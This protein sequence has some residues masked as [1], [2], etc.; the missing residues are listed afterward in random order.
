MVPQVMIVPVVVSGVN[1]TTA[2]SGSVPNTYPI[3]SFGGYAMGPPSANPPA[4]DSAGPAIA[5]GTNPVTDLPGTTYWRACIRV[6]TEKGD[7]SQT[8]LGSG[9]NAWGG[10]QTLMAITRC[11]VSNETAGSPFSVYSQ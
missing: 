1:D 6:V 11:A 9:T 8:N 3:S 10:S 5:C 7:V 4:C 2:G